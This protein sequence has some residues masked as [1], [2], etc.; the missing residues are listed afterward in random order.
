MAP[1][2]SVAAKG[3]RSEFIRKNT[4]R[5]TGSRQSGRLCWNLPWAAEL[6]DTLRNQ[7]FKTKKNIVSIPNINAVSR[8]ERELILG[9][10]ELVRWSDEQVGG[11]A[12]H[13]PLSGTHPGLPNERQRPAPPVRGRQP[14]CGGPSAPMTTRSRSCWSRDRS[15]VVKTR[16]APAVGQL[17]LRSQKNPAQKKGTQSER[18]SSSAGIHW[19]KQ[20]NS[21]K[22][23]GHTL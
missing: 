22:R 8:D 21:Q 2:E 6:A 18:T 13:E 14:T 7:S 9:S 23:Q 12:G 1:E 16:E 20:D 10:G 15:W 4:A 11:L 17:G 3:V 5:Q 19:A